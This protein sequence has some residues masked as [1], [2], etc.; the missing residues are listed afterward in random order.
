M[1]ES[2]VMQD[3][4]QS[5]HILRRLSELGVRISV[6]DFGTGYSSLSYLRRLPLDKLKI[7]RAFISEVA[8]SRD[9]AE[10]VRAIVSL[11]HSLRL[12]V[13]AEGVET[14]D[15]L[16]F[17]RTLK[18]DQYQGFHCSAPVP[19]E[20]FATL[21]RESNATLPTNPEMDDTAINRVLRQF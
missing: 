10:I 17:L 18:C 16:R 6:D 4:E 9:D 12:K 7:D 13:I 1:T 5:V 21:M 15:Q 3:A 2:A 20:Q 14:A 19:A 11:A 8:T